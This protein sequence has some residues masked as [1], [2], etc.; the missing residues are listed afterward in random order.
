MQDARSAINRHKLAEQVRTLFGAH[1]Q[2]VIVFRSQTYNPSLCLARL[3]Q[4]EYFPERV[5]EAAD[6]LSQ[7]RQAFPG[8]RSV[9]M[10]QYRIYLHSPRKDSLSNAAQ[11]QLALLLNNFL[12]NNLNYHNWIEDVIYNSLKSIDAL[13]AES[14]SLTD[15]RFL[16]IICKQFRVRAQIFRKTDDDVISSVTDH[17]TFD[18]EAVTAQRKLIRHALDKGRVIEIDGHDHD[19]SA[20][21]ET[22]PPPAAEQYA[23]IFPLRSKSRGAIRTRQFML[24][25]GR[26]LC[27]QSVLSIFSIDQCVEEYLY[28]RT[29]LGQQQCLYWQT[30]EL[31]KLV[32]HID[33]QDLDHDSLF[34]QY[35]RN[36]AR[37]VIRSTQGHS[38]GYL[39][40]DA[41]KHAL[42]RVVM[43]SDHQGFEDIGSRVSLRQSE[44]FMSAFVFNHANRLPDRSFYVKNINIPKDFEHHGL[45]SVSCMRNKLIDRGK[46]T[47]PKTVS[48]IALV[49][50]DQEMP[51][52]V[53]SVECPY[54]DGLAGDLAF[55]R[56]VANQAS[57]YW[58]FLF[59]ASDQIWLRRNLQ[60]QDI[61]HELQ[62]LVLTLE[63]GPTKKRLTEITTELDPSQ[64]SECEGEKTLSERI[65][66]L[67]E[68]ETGGSKAMAA[69]LGSAIRV[70]NP[71]H[72][73]L[74]QA[75]Q[76]AAVHIVRNLLTNRRHSS[77]FN[78]IRVVSRE[79]WTGT[80]NVLLIRTKLQMNLPKSE[81]RDAFRR[82]IRRA[83]REHVGLYMIGVIVRTRGGRLDFDRRPNINSRSLDICIPFGRIGNTDR[84]SRW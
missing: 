84:R 2:Y 15:E 36:V 13:E 60:L 47:G 6:L 44:R 38:L 61:S 74:P 75:I 50:Q 81:L 34:A 66:A 28:M 4:R 5:T 52:G 73:V 12:F 83:T 27:K 32:E 1:A 79:Q 29:R 17:G 67:I 82:P 65:D 19:L 22:G 11:E 39:T 25:T 21:R 8:T 9:R 70:H 42:R 24:L 43:T 54:R 69:D 77:V 68:E 56:Q 78:P 23:Y 41:A 80:E 30:N 64:S 20:L 18:R 59:R 31:T 7:F 37:Y 62:K 10:G 55:L 33:V 46:V 45:L 26:D 35:M 72:H 57:I 76:S 51:V 53:M 63:E 58:S 14:E 16:S 3:E 40:Y 48:E 71:A 49:I